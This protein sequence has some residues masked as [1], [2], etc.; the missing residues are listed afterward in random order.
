MSRAMGLM[1][2]TGTLA[3]LFGILSSTALAGQIRVKSSCCPE[4]VQCQPCEPAP[5]PAEPQIAEPGPEQPAPIP[6]LASEAPISSDFD[7][8][9]AMG[10]ASAPAAVAPNMIGD[11]LAPGGGQITTSVIPGVLSGSV[12]GPL[13]TASSH[14]GMIIDQG[15]GLPFLVTA[16]NPPDVWQNGQILP[17][18]S[19]LVTFI[20]L[21][22]LP[23]TLETLS[24]D[25]STGTGIPTVVGLIDPVV[26]ISPGQNPVSID[27]V[28]AQNV[29]AYEQAAARAAGAT[30]LSADATRIVSEARQV[31]SDRD[32]SIDEAAADILYLYTAVSQWQLDS[33]ITMLIPSPSAGG[34]VGRQKIGENNSPIPVD[35]VFF[36]YNYFNNAPFTATGVNVHRFTPGFEKT[37]LDRMCS[38]E[39][40]FPFASTLDSNIIVD[41]SNDTSAAEFGNLHLALKALLFRDEILAISAGLGISEPTADDIRVAAFNGAPLVRFKNEA[42]HLQPFLGTLYTP[43]ERFFA[44]GFAQL[45]FDAN[46]NELHANTRGAGLRH[47]GTIHD[48]TLLY[49]DGSLGY[50]LYHCP[51]ASQFVTGLAPMVELHLNTTINDP[52][53]VQAGTLQVQSG[54]GNFS[55]L[56]FTCGLNVELRQR[57]SMLFGLVIPIGGDDQPFDFEASVLF[58][59]QF[60]GAPDRSY[61]PTL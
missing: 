11:F 52:D 33:P 43:N 25:V 15:T 55:T 45:D 31:R 49:L 7:L 26:A 2:A 57:S 38:F 9:S 36:N 37:F 56:N 27:D 21:P 24:T 14:D 12:A 20:I 18:G 42:V 17:L 47:V 13:W 48:Q 4:P 22:P 23:A 54:P 1:R 6:D 32:E 59:Y 50:W 8:S 30:V 19:S 51:D 5:T 39:M 10:V 34:V 29:L 3:V 28:V 46:G 61:I 16:N 35:R 53:F 58:N 60:G 44:Q 41:G 40:R